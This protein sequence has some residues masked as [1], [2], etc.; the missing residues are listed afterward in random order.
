M[1]NIGELAIERP[2]RENKWCIYTG[3]MMSKLPAMNP[4]FLLR[5]EPAFVEL[6]SNTPCP[7]LPLLPDMISFT[8]SW[9]LMA[10]TKQDVYVA[11]ILARYAIPSRPSCAQVAVAMMQILLRT[12]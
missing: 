8:R 12:S 11:A 2:Q 10:G 6:G 7:M 3:L 1:V 9:V 4:V 5:Y